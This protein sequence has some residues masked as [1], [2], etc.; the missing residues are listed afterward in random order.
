[1]A[2][3]AAWAL[4][5]GSARLRV[6]GGAWLGSS[7]I[8]AS[9]SSQGGAVRHRSPLFKGRSLLPLRTQISLQEE[10]RST[11]LRNQATVKPQ[12]FDLPPKNRSKEVG[13]SLKVKAVPGSFYGYSYN[14]G[15]P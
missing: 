4:A 11:G 6:P 5:R 1:M 2:S 9:N 3:K 7:P 14:S 13:R 8:T 12:P 10:V 15:T